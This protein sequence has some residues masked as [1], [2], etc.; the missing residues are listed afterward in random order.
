MQKCELYC[1]RKIPK[2]HSNPGIFLLYTVFTALSLSASASAV[3]VT[4]SAASAAAKQYDNE[5]DDP[6]RTAAAEAV[7]AS[8]TH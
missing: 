3:V 5:N 6:R 8:A 2:P 4:A 7:I 1:I